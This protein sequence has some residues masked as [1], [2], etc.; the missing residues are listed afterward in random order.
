MTWS[1]AEYMRNVIGC[2]KVSLVPT[3]SLLSCDESVLPANDPAEEGVDDVWVL[4]WG[5]VFRQIGGFRESLSLYLLLFSSA[6]GSKGAYFGVACPERIQSHFGLSYSATLHLQSLWSQHL[7]SLLRVT[8]WKCSS[9]HT[10]VIFCSPDM[11]NACMYVCVRA[12]CF[13]LPMQTIDLLLLLF[14]SYTLLSPVCLTPSYESFLPGYG[15]VCLYVLLCLAN[16]FSFASNILS[17]LSFKWTYSNMLGFC[18]W[19]WGIFENLLVELSN[20]HYVMNILLLP[21]LK[22][23]RCC[24]FLYHSWANCFIVCQRMLCHILLNY[25]SLMAIKYIPPKPK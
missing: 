16:S 21:T 24:M 7:P 10:S 25:F 23:P 13:G 4:F 6:H 3:S 12:F 5:S 20:S 17:F 18:P 14:R 2:D 11:I 22:Y 8:L 9:L 1:W 15:T 19:V